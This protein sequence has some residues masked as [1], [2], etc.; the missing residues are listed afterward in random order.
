MIDRIVEEAIIGNYTN[1]AE[2]F[3]QELNSRLHEAI[4]DKKQSVIDSTHN[5]CESCEGEE[6]EEGYYGNPHPKKKM[7]EEEDY[8]KDDH[9]M[10][11]KSHVKK[12]DDGKFAVYHKNGKVVEKFDSEKEANAY[13]M[14]NHDDL[15][16]ESMDPVGKEDGDIDNDGDTDSSDKYLLKRRKAI[17]K[18]MKKEGAPKKVKSG[19]GY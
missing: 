8:D 19:G 6:V 14:K 12:D 5:M 9:T 13:A 18:A 3:K 2:L 17:A 4:E 15:M 7:K 11:P 10:D 16:K 1:F